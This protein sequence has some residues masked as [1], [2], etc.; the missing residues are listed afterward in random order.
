MG[1]IYTRAAVPVKVPR[2]VDGHHHQTSIFD[3]R[4]LLLSMGPDFDI[5]SVF[6]GMCIRLDR[7]RVSI[8]QSGSIVDV[9]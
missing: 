6:I 8:F 9:V 4:C 5:Q 2:N 3:P 1:L 7:G